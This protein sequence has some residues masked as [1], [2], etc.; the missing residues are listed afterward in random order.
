MLKAKMVVRFFITL[1]SSVRQLIV[2]TTDDLAGNMN[3][4]ETVEACSILCRKLSRNCTNAHQ[5]V[6][7]GLI[8][9]FGLGGSDNIIFET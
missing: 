3:A 9:K 7:K 6:A 1:Q 8:V 2:W 4:A 5:L